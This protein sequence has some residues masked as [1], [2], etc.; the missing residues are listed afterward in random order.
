LQLDSQA[1]I[2]KDKKLSKIDIKSSPIL[3]N[4]KEHT[5]EGKLKIIN[6]SDNLGFVIES[7]FSGD[8]TN[9]KGLK[10]KND[11]DIKNFNAFGINLDSIQDG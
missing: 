7:S 1:D 4:L 8:Y 10:I 11:I 5:I 2:I 3:L 6:D 9:P